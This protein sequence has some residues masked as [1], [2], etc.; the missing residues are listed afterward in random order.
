MQTNFEYHSRMPQYETLE[1]NVEAAVHI[2]RQLTSEAECLTDIEPG[3][4]ET[5]EIHLMAAQNL[6][7]AVW[8]AANELEGRLR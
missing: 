7:R 5:E 1:E 4:N 8:T 3:D 2:L 6:H